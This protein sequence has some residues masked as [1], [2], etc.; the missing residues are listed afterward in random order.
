MYYCG[1]DVESETN[2]H[3]FENLPRWTW[4][5]RA[6]LFFQS[7]KL[8]RM[9][10]HTKVL[11]RDLCLSCQ[12]LAALWTLSYAPLNHVMGDLQGEAQN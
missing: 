7:W 11:E 12:A 4:R 1:H 5:Q 6:L 2:S 10:R 8:C 9:K 3:A